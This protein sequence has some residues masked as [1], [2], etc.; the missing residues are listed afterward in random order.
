MRALGICLLVLAAVTT[1]AASVEAQNAV[2]GV[3]GSAANASDPEA[4]RVAEA[5]TLA[6][7]QSRADDAAALVHSSAL[8]SI[9]R[10]VDLWLREGSD[11]NQR[12]ELLNVRTAAEQAKLS[13]RQVFAR[14]I[15][16]V[17]KQGAREIL[18]N[19]KSTMLGAVAEGATL[20]FVGR[21]EVTMDGMKISK[22]EVLSMQQED[23]VWRVLLSGDLSGMVAALET[24]ARR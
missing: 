15:G 16:V 1:P 21:T 23:G 10:V 17:I 9:R 18:Q 20:H 14:F 13:D 2:A 22:L 5:Y 3:A 11:E 8:T 7:L 19:A 6:L 4:R 12:M 24:Q